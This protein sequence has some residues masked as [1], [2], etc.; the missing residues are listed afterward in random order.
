MNDFCRNCP[1]CDLTPA[2]ADLIASMDVNHHNRSQLRR[3][4]YDLT[5]CACGELIYLSPLPSDGDIRAMYAETGQFGEGCGCHYRGEQAAAVLEYITSCL[6]SLMRSMGA[7]LGTPLR[8]LEVG[9]GL[10]WMC[11]AA[12]MVDHQNLTVA[13][14]LTTEAVGECRWVNHYI[15]EDIL[16]SEAVDPHGP[17]DVISLTHVFEHLAEPV[18]M[19]KRLRAL[20]A[21]RGIVFITAP[22]RPL[23]WQRG[24]D[25]AGWGAWSYN[26]VPAHI[27]YFSAGS[28]AKAAAAAG[29]E[30]SR[31]DE[32]HEGGQAFEGWLRHPGSG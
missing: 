5:Y 24:A 23:G 30:V 13:Q 12:K 9:A 3:K 31:W 20:L 7:D 29:L 6:I 8:V 28:F 25:V 18:A 22:H 21:T 11:R 14:D 19:L 17:Y 1:V 2:P 27:Q 10:A 32:G 15:V 26:H 4:S 16:T